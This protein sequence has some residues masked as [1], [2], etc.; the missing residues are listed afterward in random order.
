MKQKPYLIVILILSIMLVFE[1]ALLYSDLKKEPAVEQEEE[2]GGAEVEFV[3][4][5]KSLV[6]GEYLFP[7]A[8]SEYYLTSPYGKRVSPILDIWLDHQGLDIGGPWQCQIQAVA[9]GTVVEY[10]PPPDGYFRGHN[11]FGGYIVIEHED[12]TASKY[13][14]LSA[15][16][17]REGLKVE[18]GTIIG[19]MGSTG[20]STGQ[21]LHFE[22][23]VEGE[24]VNPLL[25]IQDPRSEK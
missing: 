1:S 4:P 21:H 9:K 14:H 7:L 23:I 17:V 20:K 11:V 15:G 25:Y 5:T 12:G 19:R 2:I 6:E 10:W 22:F 18:A 24:S 3:E 13:A 8:D 16:Y